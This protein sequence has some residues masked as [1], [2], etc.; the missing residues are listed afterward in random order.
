MLV[1]GATGYARVSFLGSVL[2]WKAPS[3]S[4]APNLREVEVRAQSFEYHREV[5]ERSRR[6]DEADR[7]PTWRRCMEVVNVLEMGKTSKENRVTL[8]GRGEEGNLTE[9]NEKFQFVAEGGTGVDAPQSRAGRQTA[10]RKL[11]D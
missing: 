2:A 7:V 5:C 9:L 10:K 4:R 8:E 3:C 11:L 1:A 6:I